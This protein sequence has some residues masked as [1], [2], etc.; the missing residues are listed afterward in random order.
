MPNLSII[1]RSTLAA[2]GFGALLTS[3]CVAPPT[4]PSAPAL[5]PTE[6]TIHPSTTTVYVQTGPA[7]RLVPASDWPQFHDVME[8]KSL[9]KVTEKSL[10]YLK[11]QETVRTF[12][13]IGNRDV[14]PGELEATAEE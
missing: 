9:A 5:P 14:A 7:L 2:M 10:A 6:G 8:M 3:A 13:R 1:R 4:Q 12:Y 11:Q